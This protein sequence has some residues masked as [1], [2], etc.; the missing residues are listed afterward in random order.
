MEM[1]K[2]DVFLKGGYLDHLEPLGKFIAWNHCGYTNVEICALCISF[3]T[4]RQQQ[5]TSDLKLDEL[6]VAIGIP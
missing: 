4:L 5:I 3:M 6:I 1:T 2:N